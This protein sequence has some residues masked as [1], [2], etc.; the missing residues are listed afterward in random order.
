MSAKYADN[1]PQSPRPSGSARRYERRAA[2]SGPYG[3][4]PWS[5][6]SPAKTRVPA[7]LTASRTSRVFPTPASPATRS[8]PPSP[9]PTALSAASSA[10][11]SGSRPISAA[12]GMPSLDCT[13]AR[14]ASS[15]EDYALSVG[16]TVRV[17]SPRAGSRRAGRTR[18]RR[19]HAIARRRRGRGTGRGPAQSPIAYQSTANSSTTPAAMS[20][21]RIM[22]RSTVELGLIKNIRR[23]AVSGACEVPYRAE[24]AAPGP[25]ARRSAPTLPRGPRFES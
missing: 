25:S 18:E 3:G 13:A 7:P 12:A 16:T 5:N 22:V 10:A 23:I 24:R 4:V 17:P 2:T 14:G 11:S 6:A 15:R 8:S 21:V 9:A 20:V 19:L 1:P